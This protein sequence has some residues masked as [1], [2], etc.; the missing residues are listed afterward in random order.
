M[1]SPAAIVP[2]VRIL[3]IVQIVQI[4]QDRV[5]MIDRIHFVK[6]NQFLLTKFVS[7]LFKDRLG[8]ILSRTIK[9][10]VKHET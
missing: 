10:Q 4:V 6:F 5:D 3:P 2:I 7:L 1:R 8:F 9:C